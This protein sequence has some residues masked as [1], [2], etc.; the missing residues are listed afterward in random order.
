MDKVKIAIVGC[1]TI[2]QLNVPGY[3]A[4]S[5]C[6]VV[7]LCDP[8]VDRAV[9]RAKEWG[10]SPRI[11]STYEQVLEDG[12]IDAVELLTPTHMHADQIVRGLESGKHVSCQKPLASTIAEAEVITAAVR[13]SDKKFRITENFLHYPPIIKAKELLESGAIGEPNMLRM[14]TVRAKLSES[15]F[16]IGEDA[17]KWRADATLQ[18][19]GA[20]YDDGWHKY[21]TAIRWLGEIESVQGIISNPDDREDELPAAAMWKFKRNECL[22]VYDYSRSEEMTIRGKYYGGEDFFAIQGTK[23]AIWVTRCTS[24][25]LDMAPVVLMRGIETISYQVPMEWMESF[26]G[27]ATHFIECILND[28]QPDMD[29]DFSNHTL[30]VALSV[31]KASSEQRAVTPSTLT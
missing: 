6:Q 11:Y 7:A 24:E 1:G 15:D 12:K 4:N 19:G 27:A 10:I 2:S 8:D 5:K 26:N 25:M 29:I 9:S 20:M 16:S 22:G 31:Y 21:A 13:K 17:M 30:R 3:L 28:Q 14:R 23:R 18:A